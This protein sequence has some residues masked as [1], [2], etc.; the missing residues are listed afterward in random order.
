MVARRTGQARWPMLPK[1]GWQVRQK[2]SWS[3]PSSFSQVLLQGLHQ[4]SCIVMQVCRSP[5]RW[6][7]WAHNKSHDATIEAPQLS[8]VR[9]HILLWKCVEFTKWGR[10]GVMGWSFLW[11]GLGCSVSCC[12]GRLCG[13]WDGFVRL[14]WMFEVGMWKQLWSFYV[15]KDKDSHSSLFLTCLY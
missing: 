6:M 3:K 8:P 7:P 4:P 13:R 11:H 9:A 1:S 2:E 15:I 12:L 14:A 5:P 10:R